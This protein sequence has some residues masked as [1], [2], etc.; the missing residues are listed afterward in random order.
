MLSRSAAT[1]RPG[2]SSQAAD[3]P[4]DDYAAVADRVNGVAG[5]EFALPLVEG[6]TLA[7]GNVGAGSGALVRGIRPEDFP[8]I[9]LVSGN[10][11]EGSLEA[12]QMAKASQSARAWRTIWAFWSVT[13]SAGCCSGKTAVRNLRPWE[14]L[15]PRPCSAGLSCTKPEVQVVFHFPLSATHLSASNSN[16]SL[17]PKVPLAILF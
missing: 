1:H 5:V 4:L 8:R 15:P 6:Q 11:K 10:I 3:T 7:S 17:Q 13:G 14:A 16:Y 2:T 12:W 9:S